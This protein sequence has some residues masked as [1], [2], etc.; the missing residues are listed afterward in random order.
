[1]ERNAMLVT[2]LTR[3]VADSALAVPVRAA[4]F[5]SA[6]Q[7]RKAA[8]QGSNAEDAATG[9]AGGEQNTQRVSWCAVQFQW[10][11]MGLR[12][13]RDGA[14]DAVIVIKTARNGRKCVQKRPLCNGWG[15][16][17]CSPCHW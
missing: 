5:E 3:A 17:G 12:W 9:S 14:V 11:P 15:G 10:S 1:M 6:R 8:T 2:T 16:I 13:A 7:Q 4:E